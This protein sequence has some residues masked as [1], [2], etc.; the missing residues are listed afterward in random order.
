[1]KQ[2]QFG[3]F[4]IF[5]LGVASTGSA[6]TESSN[7]ITISGI[8]I[9]QTLT[10]QGRRFFKSFSTSW[11]LLEPRDEFNLAVKE[12]PDPA[13]SSRIQ[14]TWNH[15]LLYATLL[16]PAR[17]QLK[18]KAEQAANVVNNKLQFIRIIEATQSDPDMDKDEI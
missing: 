9:D 14:I 15:R 17:N 5:F 3:L 13:K 7:E 2:F 12:F 4:L 10:P 8:L 1:M 18:Q 11:R 16:G 6:S